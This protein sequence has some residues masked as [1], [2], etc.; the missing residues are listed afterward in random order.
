MNI[1]QLVGSKI[2]QAREDQGMS[3][4]ELGD[5]LEPY[6][7]RAWPRP[8]ISM[9]E[10][11]RQELVAAELL[12]FAAVL[13][14]PVSWFLVPEDG[15]DGLQLRGRQ[16]L[17]VDDLRSITGT[18][19]EGATEEEPEEEE[20]PA[21]EVAEPEPEPEDTREAERLATLRQVTWDLREAV[22]RLRD[23]VSNVEQ[24]AERAHDAASSP[25]RDEDGGGATD[26]DT[27]V[28]ADG[29]AGDA[30]TS[31]EDAEEEATE[32]AEPT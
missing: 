15:D 31:E 4:D 30:A 5:A 7:G 10:G 25:T 18:G 14:R 3:E 29:S 32:E 11:G 21:E 1:D 6:L 24:L 22:E 16:T 9:A 19:L 8:A 26:D 17:S 28:S 20:D 23:S 27:L 12:A 2:R 13:N